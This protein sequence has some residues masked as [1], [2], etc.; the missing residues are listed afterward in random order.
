M[1]LISS[2]LDTVENFL[3]FSEMRS[4]PVWIQHCDCLLLSLEKVMQRHSN[5]MQEYDDLTVEV[6]LAELARSNYIQCREVRCKLD[7]A[8]SEPY[9]A[10]WYLWINLEHSFGSS[11]SK[12]KRRGKLLP[13]FLRYFSGQLK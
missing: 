3:D 5:A 12:L 11:K 4:D 10:T 2:L 7:L 9:L 8:W 1:L 13:E 6:T